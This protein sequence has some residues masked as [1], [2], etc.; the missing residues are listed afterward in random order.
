[1]VATCSR[2]LQIVG[3]F[4]KRASQKRR[5]S[6]NDTYNFKEL[7]DC[8]HPIFYCVLMFHA[9][10]TRNGAL[11]DHS[12]TLCNTLQHTATRC[13]TRN[14]LQHTCFMQPFSVPMQS[15]ETKTHS[16]DLHFLLCHVFW[17][18]IDS[19]VSCSARVPRHNRTQRRRLLWN[20][21]CLCS[22]CARAASR[23]GVRA[24][25][26]GRYCCSVL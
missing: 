17:W 8:S 26:Q 7:T 18:F 3:L 12:A 2:L 19:D 14:T 4:W 13:N 20:C 16:D 23:K 1:M 11:P 9:A 10:T 15:H 5:Y 24:Q 6:A 22:K 21:R 25:G